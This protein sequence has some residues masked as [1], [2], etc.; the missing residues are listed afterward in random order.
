M[1]SPRRLAGERPADERFGH[2]RLAMTG[3]LAL[4]FGAG[5]LSP[6]N[7][8]GFALLPAYLGYYLGVSD[9]D[10]RAGASLG[11]R[12]AQGLR[13]GVVLTLGFAGTLSVLGLAVTAGARPL[14]AAAPWLGLVVGAALA[15][16]GARMLT[17]RT[18]ALRLPSAVRAVR[19][20]VTAP[21]ST[22]TS[23]SLSRLAAFGA[24]YALASL[25]CIVGV[26]L[27]VI[28]QAL[29][30]ASLAGVL[31]VFAA[32]AAGAATLLVLVSVSAALASGL[33]IGRIRAL[34]PVASRLAGAVLGLAGVYLVVY[35]A[36]VTQARGPGTLLGVGLQPLA[37]RVATWIAAH[38]TVT[39]LLAG[40][41]ILAALTTA[42][43]AA[44][45]SRRRRPAS[46]P[47]PGDQQQPDTQDAGRRPADPS[48]LGTDRGADRGADR[49]T[50]P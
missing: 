45:S 32:Y 27:A 22:S 50:R 24:A 15:V 30:A 48:R 4:A 38:Q 49:T 19:P 11:G 3:L 6:V 5:M 1:P 34:L 26:L 46:T 9:T 20:T 13:A 35:W 39:A 33:L 16:L 7:P 21:T 18:V 17:G 25:A 37:A 29:A 42:L 31:V 36:P 23:T 43:T 47:S 12:L 44:A 40:A 8:C 41:V 28:G 2:L 14:L 10:R